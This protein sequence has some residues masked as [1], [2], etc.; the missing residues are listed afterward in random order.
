MSAPYEIVAAPFAVYRAPVGESFPDVDEAPAGNWSLIGSSGARNY[1]GEGVTVVHAQEIEE[2]RPLGSTGPV[3]A[4]RTSEGLVVRFTLWDM[5]LEQYTHALNDNAVATTAA[6]AGTPGFKTL[7]LYRGLDVAL[8]A[9]LVRG[10]VSPEGAGW[11]SQYQVP[12]C[13]QAAAPEPVFA[14][15]APA[16]LALEFM[17][18]EDPNAASAA[19]RFGA[20]LVQHQTAI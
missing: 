14:K 10:D 17:A 9:L 18:L 20:L 7:Q 8:L 6:G 12:V 4:L 19:E 15:G 3:K 13:Y 5:L 16:G 1:S 2:V 11:K